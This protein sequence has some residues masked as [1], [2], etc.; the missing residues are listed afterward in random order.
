MFQRSG[1]YESQDILELSSIVSKL[2][3]LNSVLDIGERFIVRDYT[4]RG[5]FGVTRIDRGWNPCPC[6]QKA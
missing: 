4:Q 6:S 2:G 1:V 3:E 5:S